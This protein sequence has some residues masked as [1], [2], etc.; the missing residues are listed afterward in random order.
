LGTEI[1]LEAFL[2]LPDGSMLVREAIR[3]PLANPEALGA[4]LGQRLLDAGGRQVLDRLA[5]TR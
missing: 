2:G 5:A 3:G 1:S 4:Q